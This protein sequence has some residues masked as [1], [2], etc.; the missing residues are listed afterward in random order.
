MGGR[1][2]EDEYGNAPEP[3]A[4]AEYIRSLAAYQ[5]QRTRGHLAAGTRP[6]AAGGNKGGLE[7]RYGP[8]R[9]GLTGAFREMRVGGGLSDDDSGSES[10]GEDDRRGMRVMGRA[11]VKARS[12]AL[13][14]VKGGWNGSFFARRDENAR[15]MNS[16][17]KA[18]ATRVFQRQPRLPL[19]SI[20]SG[21][22]VPEHSP[23]M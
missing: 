18:R 16:A 6:P 7:V 23:I 20:P 2:D 10:D 11:T 17:A 9:G 5:A 19:A 15:R 22:I 12:H 1:A 8:G 14:E 21:N 13:L 3:V 4:A